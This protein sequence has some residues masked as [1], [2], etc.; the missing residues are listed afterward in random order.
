M[1]EYSFSHSHKTHT[2]PSFFLTSRSPSLNRSNFQFLIYM[3]LVDP[4][5]ARS[6]SVDSRTSSS[7]IPVL[8][9]EYP[10]MITSTSTKTRRLTSSWGV[11][12]SHYFT[13]HDLGPISSSDLAWVGSIQA[14]GQPLV[15]ILA[16]ILAQRIGY[17]LTGFIGTC[18]MCIGLISCIIFYSRMAF[19][20]HPRCIVRRWEWF[21]IHSCCLYTFT[22]GESFVY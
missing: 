17:R 2:T 18:I 11:Y 9:L 10:R 20:P 14:T 4:A 19:I 3:K 21:R 13:S 16:G 22:M 8:L 6:P 1:S 7:S 12:Q 15:G 5:E